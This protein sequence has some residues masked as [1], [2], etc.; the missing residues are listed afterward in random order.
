MRKISDLEIQSVTG[1]GW[2]YDLGN[3]IGDL[4][5]SIE[6]AAADALTTGIGLMKNS[7]YQQEYGEL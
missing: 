7:L 2:F 3:A 6:A 4:Q 1:A 5:N